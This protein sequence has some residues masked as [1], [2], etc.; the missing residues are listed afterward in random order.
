[1]AEYREFRKSAAGVGDL[2]QKE[3]AVQRRT[4]ANLL[5]AD[6]QLASV[7][8]S[9]TV[10]DAAIRMQAQDCG[11]VVVLEQGQLAGIFTER[12]LLMRVVAKGLDPDK[13]RISQVMTANPRTVSTQELALV[14]LRMMEDGNYRHV[15]VTRDGQVVAWCRGAT[16]PAM[17]SPSWKSNDVIGI[18]F[19]WLT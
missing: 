9:A 7:E 12:D 6:H 19:K 3:G 1:L 5:N 4:V 15:P 10:R 17:K 2:R 18:G 13:T 11:S 14:C 16:S 8:A